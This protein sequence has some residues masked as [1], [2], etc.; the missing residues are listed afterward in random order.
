MRISSPWGDERLL[1]W[2][3]Y[4]AM[5]EWDGQQQEM[6]PLA[7]YSLDHPK[8]PY[9]VADMRDSFAP[10]RREMFRR[11]VTDATAG[12]LGV[13]RTAN[14]GLF[15]A[16]FAWEFMTSRWGAPNDRSWRVRSYAELRYRLAIDSTLAPD[17]RKELSRRANWLAMNPFEESLENEA[18][19]ARIQHAALVKWAQSPQGAGAKL[20]KDRREE[21]ALLR[22]SE[23]RRIWANAS[24]MATFGLY[25]KRAPDVPA[26]YAELD[27][28]RRVSTHK[29]LLEQ[30]LD[31]GDPRPEVSWNMT[32]VRNAVA[33]LGRL[34]AGDAEVAAL[35]DKVL[36]KID[37][38]E[39]RAAFVEAWNATHP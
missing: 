20:N 24:R 12:V 10:G 2:K 16:S 39:S 15:A 21:L 37:D 4:S 11:A 25:R 7:L 6:I 36:A 18:R 34:K 26:S 31:S 28:R 35:M 9:L 27:T 32:E 17:L 29:R 30:L 19:I 1:N 8:T 14:L 33:E 5:R 13:T 22:R 23:E 3:G 38:N